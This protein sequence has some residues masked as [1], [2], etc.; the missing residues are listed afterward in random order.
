[1]A[2]SHPQLPNTM[3]EKVTERQ[4]S[5]E[6]SH[7]GPAGH[8]LDLCADAAPARSLTRPGDS[9]PSMPATGARTMA[10]PP[11]QGS[12]PASSSLP[13]DLQGGLETA[14]GVSMAGVRVVYGSSEPARY[15]AAAFARKGVI[16]LGPGQDKFLDHEA[17]H[18]G[19]QRLGQVRPTGERK[20]QPVNE[21]ASMEAA[22]DHLAAQAKRKADPA[23]AAE[24][25][26]ALQQGQ[27]VDVMQFAPANFVGH[28]VLREPANTGLFRTS[29]W[30]PLRA[31]VTA[32]S[33]TAQADM[34]TRLKLLREMGV[35][36]DRWKTARGL[37]DRA[38]DLN[39]EE[40]NKLTALNVLRATMS[41]EYDELGHSDGDLVAASPGLAHTSPE[42]ELTTVRKESDGRKRGFFLAGASVVNAQNVN[43]A[44]PATGTLCRVTK[45]TTGPAGTV[46]DLYYAVRPAPGEDATFGT[47]APFTSGFVLKSQVN[48]VNLDQAASK[49]LQ[50]EDRFD[51]N[52]HPLF[53]APPSVIDVE[54][55]GL[56]DCYLMASLLT[57][58]RHRPDHFTNH[59]VDHGDGV[60][61]VQLYENIGGVFA[62]KMVHVR[63]SVVVKKAAKTTLEEGYNK[64][65][66]WVQLLE[67]AYIAAGFSG[68][69]IE[70]LPTAKTQWSQAASGQAS[71]ALG[72]LTGVAATDT[73]I[74]SIA[75]EE[76]KSDSNWA[77]NHGFALMQHL[78]DLDPENRV[79]F[80]QYMAIQNALSTRIAALKDTKDEIRLA[81]V[82]P[83]I[84]N[85]PGLGAT[86]ADEIVNWL[87]TQGIYPGGKRGKALYSNAQKDA[88]QAVMT[89]VR[90][91]QLIVAGSKGH[92]KRGDN[93]RDG[94]S[95]GENVRNGLAGPHG[96]EVID[97]RMQASIADDQVPEPNT[98]CWIQL[99]NPWG[100]TGRVY[101][102]THDNADMDQ[103][104]HAPV[105]G[106]ME[107]RKTEEAEFWIP[108]EDFTKRF[109]VLTTL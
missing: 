41:D 89:A 49:T 28:P 82:E 68:D 65:A 63:K 57:L 97:F 34:K 38:E 73:R 33:T 107:D 7:E 24:S 19:Q 87:A 98:I 109:N 10:P 108:L 5:Q 90:A 51:P 9:A 32:Y 72:H 76:F 39:Q 94:S 101:K 103:T 23:P 27:D 47:V 17:A 85:T 91:G 44:N 54:Q 35:F 20:G 83:V 1:M 88:F 18:I 81:D 79:L 15:G 58:V 50:Y 59:M 95:G 14:L 29:Y 93:N 21:D 26:P 61:S 52:T 13:A 66:I 71:I 4:D 64:G 43:V 100:H 106:K 104:D 62:P 74:A 11:M 12:T 40:R 84:R 3:S 92:M 36:S 37:P 67:K 53:P 8:P 70:T 56:G 48:A 16:H 60:V 22:A 86:L 80:I 46:A 45:T 55:S 78:R 99:R 105:V 6:T 96:Y 25:K 42:P 69:N 30:T 2:V 102:D 77:G 75:P 31:A